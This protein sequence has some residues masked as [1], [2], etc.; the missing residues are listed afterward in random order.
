MLSPLANGLLSPGATPSVHY[1]NAE[2]KARINAMIDEAQGSAKAAMAAIA[3]IDSEYQA[4]LGKYELMQRGVQDLVREAQAAEA[5]SALRGGVSAQSSLMQVDWGSDADDGQ[6]LPPYG[7]GAL[8][9]GGSVTSVDS[10]K[11]GVSRGG[12]RFK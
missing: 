7:V 12:V 1:S 10:F 4:L 3:D 9:S 5:E 8:D 11:G 2:L 6:L